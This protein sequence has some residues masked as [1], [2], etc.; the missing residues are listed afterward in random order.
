[1]DGAGAA[2]DAAKGSIAP[3]AAAAPSASGLSP[4]RMAL[5]LVVLLGL[6]HLLTDFMDESVRGQ[7]PGP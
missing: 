2:K 1:M 4:V 7:A 3:A 6:N 5:G